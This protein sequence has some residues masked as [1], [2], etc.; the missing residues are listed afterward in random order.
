MTQRAKVGYFPC[1]AR[2]AHVAAP[3]SYRA[4]KYSG[5]KAHGVQLWEEH[6][7]RAARFFAGA[8]YAHDSGYLSPEWD[9]AAQSLA[10]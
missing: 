10:P 2:P 4:R 8:V 5:R 9:W 1:C 6:G 3:S 7:R